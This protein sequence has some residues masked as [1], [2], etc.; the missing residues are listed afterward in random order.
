MTGNPNLEMAVNL[1]THGGYDYIIKPFMI[2]DFIKKIKS[3]I[4]TFKQKK[5]EKT[6]QGSL[7]QLPYHLPAG[8]RIRLPG[9]S[10]RPDHRIGSVW[11]G[12]ALRG[13]LGIS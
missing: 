2:P 10:R 3:V 7:W 12:Q 9:K 6:F 11:C 8:N 1:L 4:N 13:S 5:E